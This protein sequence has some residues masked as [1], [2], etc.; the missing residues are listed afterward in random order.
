MR[1]QILKVLFHKNVFLYGDHF[2]VILC[3]KGK[4]VSLVT[5]KGTTY[6]RLNGRKAEMRHAEWPA[7]LWQETSCLTPASIRDR[8]AILWR[9]LF[10]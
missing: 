3:G 6:F 5:D 2:V 1:W 9:A 4:Q 7:D 10:V 8:L